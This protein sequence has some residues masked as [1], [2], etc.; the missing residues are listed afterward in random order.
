MATYI[1]NRGDIVHLEFDPALGHEMKGR[2]FGLVISQ[3]NFNLRGLAMICPIS[4]GTANLERTFG[5]I[6]SL[7]GL[8]IDSQGAVFCH[9]LKSLDWRYRQ[10]SFKEKLPTHIVDD[11]VARIEA[12]INN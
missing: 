5:T 2:H 9:Q 12:I 4:Q 11:V 1:P 3:K 6:V 8:G 7:M 10:A